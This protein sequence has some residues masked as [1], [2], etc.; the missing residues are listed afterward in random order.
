MRKT[1]TIA[2]ATAVMTIVACGEQHHDDATTSATTTAAQ[3]TTTATAPPPT[4]TTAPQPD[5]AA[6][7]A[8]VKDLYAKQDASQ[9]PFFR[10]A[11]DRAAV[12]AYFDASLAELI[13]KDA[14]HPDGEVG[15]LDF[16]PI[17]NAQDTDIKN[18]EFQPATVTGDIARV[19]VTFAN[20]DKKEQITYE[21]TAASGSWKITNIH[22]ADG[23][24]LRDVYKPQS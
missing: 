4:A 3:T 8:L 2:V 24:T 18:L 16:D 15:A 21:L 6:A 12:D 19:P 5:P 7:V 1:L 23:R 20:F 13:V 14:D 10:A 22:Y 11:S 9:G 17:Y